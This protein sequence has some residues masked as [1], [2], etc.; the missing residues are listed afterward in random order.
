M[1]VSRRTLL[2]GTAAPAAFTAVNIRTRPAEAAEFSY[3]YAGNLPDTHPLAKR[4]QWAAD[5]IKVETNGRMEIQCF[6]NNQLGSDTDML[7]QLRSGALEFFTMSGAILATFI[8]IASINSIGFAYPDE[9]TALAS[10]D[11][12]LG[13]YIRDEVNKTTIGVFDKIWGHG[14][15]QITTGPKPIVRPE[16]LHGFRLRLPATP[17]WVSMFK[18]LGASPTSINWSETYSALQTKI[19]DGQENPLAVIYANKIYEVQ[20]Y[21]SLT[22]HIWEGYW[23][24]RNKKTWAALP[25]DLQETV[26]RVFDEAALLQRQ[27]LVE[28][29]MTL[30]TELEKQ[31]MI[32]NEPD[33]MPFREALSKAGFYK[34]WREKYGAE[35][36]KLLEKYSG[37]LA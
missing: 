1:S 5:K 32:M 18:A 33:R 27:D 23:M 37:P 6:P 15:R 21:C 30:R 7:S 17:S 4:T 13:Q 26:A 34:E 31:G 12:D 35:P 3:K 29:S 9:K 28:M 11:G 36:W 25:K 10:L 16:D 8:P 22:S 14:Y 24:L 20:K 2:Q 19:V